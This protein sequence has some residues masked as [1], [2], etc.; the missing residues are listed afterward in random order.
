MA[1]VGLML[2]LWLGL[3]T[4]SSS[5]ELHQVLHP[6]AHHLSHECLVTYFTKSHFLFVSTVLMVSVIL[7]ADFSPVPQESNAPD[8]VGDL[9]LGPSRAPPSSSFFT[10]V[11]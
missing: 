10:S 4:L 9:R 3:V 8:A 5:S 1:A 6:D 11:C 2:V 7:C